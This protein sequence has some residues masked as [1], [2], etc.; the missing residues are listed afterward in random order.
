[1]TRLLYVG[2]HA[3]YFLSHRL[4]VMR[5][6]QAHGYEVHVAVPPH[7]DALEQMI[8]A[9]A[10]TE[11]QQLG[12]ILHPIPIARGGLQPIH[13]L[14]SLWRLHRLYRQLQPDL[15]Y[16]ATIKPVLYGGAAA[17]LARVPAVI[18]AMTGLGY[19]FSGSS[20]KARL[21]RSAFSTFYQIVMGH[22]NAMALFQNQDDQRTLIDAGLVRENRTVVIHGSGVDM[23]QYCPAPHPAETPVVM[24]ASRML[25]DKG[26]GEFVAAA[27]CCRQNGIGARFVLVGDT[28]PDNPAAIPR[29]QLQAWHDRGE[30]EWWGWQKDMA[31]TLQQADVFC[32]PSFYREG[33]PKALIEA[34]ATGLPIVTTDA[35]GCREVVRQ[36]ENGLLIPVRDRDALA[37]ALTQLIQDADQRQQMGRRSREIAIDTFSVETVASQTIGLC[38]TLLNRKS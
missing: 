24:L 22:P 19:A 3:G 20:I 33:I 16:H 8:T 4:P 6:L 23:N 29:P 35:P 1:M 36:G 34:A 28:D 26:I 18:N 30:I 27:G 25:W 9:D 10:M 15:V 38:E 32:L 11:I 7:A 37:D 17:R 14:R 5:A 2:N 21:I 13:E 12:F 31:A